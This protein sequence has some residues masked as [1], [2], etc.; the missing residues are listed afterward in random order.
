LNPK[1][2]R[3]AG[4]NAS[5]ASQCSQGSSARSRSESPQRNRL[6]QA[7]VEAGLES[8]LKSSPR[9][10]RSWT[11]ANASSW[12]TANEQIATSQP[13]E[14]VVRFDPIVP[15][16]RDPAWASELSG[17]GSNLPSQMESETNSEC[18]NLWLKRSDPQHTGDAM[19]LVPLRSPA[20]RSQISG[21]SKL[22]RSRE[23]QTPDA[24]TEWPQYR[25]G[26]IAIL[27]GSS[28]RVPFPSDPARHGAFS[29]CV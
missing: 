21:G 16:S 3:Q 25:R 20:P 22:T 12:N 15:D 18:S 17:K 27:Q 2:W 24:C 5:T 23:L 6:C 9:T 28:Q 29:T 11:T 7:V 19:H 13:R 1:V 4:R 10:S 26:P 8:P 14:S